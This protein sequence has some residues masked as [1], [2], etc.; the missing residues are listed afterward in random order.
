M[1][2]QQ[3]KRRH[4][5]VTNRFRFVVFSTF[6]ILYHSIFS[7]KRQRFANTSNHSIF[8]LKQQRFTN[9]LNRST[10][11]LKRQRFTKIFNSIKKQIIQ[12]SILK[13]IEFFFTTS[14]KFFNFV[15]A[16]IVIEKK[17]KM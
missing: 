12:S 16:R 15:Y 17:T 11:S 14:V 6:N 7:L 1:N 2:N 8:S 3:R 9:I 10:F 4:R 5:F 13:K